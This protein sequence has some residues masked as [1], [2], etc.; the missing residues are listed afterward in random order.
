[1]DAVL[2]MIREDDVPSPSK[3]LSEPDSSLKM[4]ADQRQSDPARL[5]KEIQGELD[6]ITTKCLEKDRTR[7]YDSASELPRT[8]RDS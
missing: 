6:W 5:C 1:M 7:R 8:S 2:R 3:R 4:L